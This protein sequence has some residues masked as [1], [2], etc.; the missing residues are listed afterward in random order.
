MFVAL[1]GVVGIASFDASR[2]STAA[3][4]DFAEE[5]G[6]LA[7]SLGT[8]MVVSSSG[9]IPMA[10]LHGM[11]HERERVV[12]LARD[13]TDELL[14]T[15]GT[16]EH[17]SGIRNAL[18]DREPWVRLTRA[19]A[20]A[21]GLPARS[22]VA[23]FG[24]VAGTDTH[25]VVLTSAARERDRELRVQGRLVASIL[26]G[27]VL[28]VAFGLAALR[29]QR[30][31]LELA[32]E[33]AV[34]DAARSRDD[35]LARA[36]R[37]AALGAFGTGIAHEI[38]SPLGVIVGRAEQ[39]LPKV[40]SDPRAKKAVEDIALHAARISQTIRDF[41]GLARGEPPSLAHVG[42]D[43]IVYRARE[44]VAHR[45]ASAGVELRILVD[46]PTPSVACDV[47]LFVHALVNLLL[48]ACDASAEGTSVGLRASREAHTVTF[49]V[50]DEGPGIRTEDAARVLE[51][52]FTTK[53]V[54]AG[55]GLGLAIAAEIVKHHQGRLLVEPRGP[56]T[57]G[58][59][60]VLE[61]PALN[62][63]VG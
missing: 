8:G 26:V 37:F 43:V 57:R 30:H 29:R 42:A 21:L 51:P 55:S 50:L 20:A 15:D 10:P 24:N 59:R 27:G 32:R 35:Q 13:G 60:A 11:E 34:A 39:L 46:E 22:A 49:E 5:Q 14:R 40:E 23:A 53:P 44:F 47:R 61:L 2:E 38:S 31:E 54:G 3:F 4:H 17:S 45:F 6:L 36:S 1:A 12:F 41:S 19:E 62:E 33:L 16:K 28:V 7:R 48:N 18:R 63:E 25:V 58:T 56:T 52:F 9:A